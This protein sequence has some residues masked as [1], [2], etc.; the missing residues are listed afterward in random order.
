MKS[1][2]TIFFIDKTTKNHDKIF[3]SFYLQKNE[4]EQSRWQPRV[5]TTKTVDWVNNTLTKS[6]KNTCLVE[7]FSILE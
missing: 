2:K 6:L 4:E 1:D 7:L 3:K 5:D